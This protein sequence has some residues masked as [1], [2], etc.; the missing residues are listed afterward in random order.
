[1]IPEIIGRKFND[2]IFQADMR[3]WPFRVIQGPDQRPQIVVQYK[4]K[5]NRFFPEEMLGHDPV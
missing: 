5:E 3:H 1:M 2:P 4:G